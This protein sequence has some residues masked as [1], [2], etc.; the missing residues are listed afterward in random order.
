LPP[1]QCIGT[2]I[3]A[4]AAWIASVRQRQDKAKLPA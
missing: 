2:E 1:P 4:L 3:A